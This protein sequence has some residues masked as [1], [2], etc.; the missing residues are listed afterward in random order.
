MCFQVQSSD[1]TIADPCLNFNTRTVRVIHH[2]EV[3]YIGLFFMIGC[4][5]DRS[6]ARPPSLSLDA[7]SSDDK[8][9]LAASLLLSTSD[10]NQ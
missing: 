6:E 3:P 10:F 5:P 8:L 1:Q 4:P 7:V 2:I 9:T